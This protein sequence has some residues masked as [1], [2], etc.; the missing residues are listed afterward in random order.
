M[1]DRKKSRNTDP[2]LLSSSN[3]SEGEEIKMLVFGIGPHS[4]WGRIKLSLQVDE[5]NTPLQD[6]L[7]AIATLIGYIGTAVAVLTFLVMIAYLVV[8]DGPYASGVIDALILAVTIVVVAVPGEQIALLV[9]NTR[10]SRRSCCKYEH[11]VL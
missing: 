10:T 6:K 8:D 11:T 9:H 2:F 4:Q 7:D 1:E 5:V 3:I